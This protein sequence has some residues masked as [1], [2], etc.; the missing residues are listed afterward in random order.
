[1]FELH[2]NANISSSL[3]KTRELLGSALSLQGAAGGG[4]GGGWEDSVTTLCSAI[5]KRIPSPYD[6]GKVQID[7][8]IV[9]NES[10]NTVLIQELMRF[11]RLGQVRERC[12][13]RLCKLPHDQCCIHRWLGDQKVA[14]RH[15]AQYQ[16]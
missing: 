12:W 5:E 8:P 2:P 3:S 4:S 13:I 14:G 15:E 16:G 6:V 1:M 7:Y 10:M 9:Y 11:N